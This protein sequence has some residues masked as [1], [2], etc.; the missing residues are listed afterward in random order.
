MP[1]RPCG[2]R[3][4]WSFMQGLVRIGQQRSKKQEVVDALLFSDALDSRGTLPGVFMKSTNRPLSRAQRCAQGMPSE[5]VRQQAERWGTSKAVSTV[6]PAMM[7][8][9]ADVEPGPLQD[10]CPNSHFGA[11]GRAEVSA[12][13]VSMEMIVEHDHIDTAA[14]DACLPQAKQQLPAVARR[15]LSARSVPACVTWRVGWWN[16]QPTVSPL[17]RL[18]VAAVRH[19]HGGH[20][21]ETASAREGEGTAIA[22]LKAA[23]QRNCVQVRI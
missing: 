23:R 7:Q 18:S 5:T 13:G 6:T 8:A 14:A 4:G 1:T 2:P 3:S 11:L 9:V 17:V 22:G 10:A 15:M 20:S 16:A 21:F 19:G 12:V